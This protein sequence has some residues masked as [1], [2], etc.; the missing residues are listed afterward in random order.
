MG[1]ISLSELIVATQQMSA[2]VTSSPANHGEF[3]K[4]E[5]VKLYADLIFA[6]PSGFKDGSPPKKIGS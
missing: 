2:T 4:N 3:A 5:F 6:I 1:I